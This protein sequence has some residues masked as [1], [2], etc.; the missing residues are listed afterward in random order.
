[1]S[2]SLTPRCT[3]DAPFL[4]L[5]LGHLAPASRRR[6]HNRIW[7]LDGTVP[8]IITSPSKIP[9]PPALYETGGVVPPG[10]FPFL[11]TSGLNQIRMWVVLKRWGMGNGLGGRGMFEVEAL[12]C[13]AGKAGIL[14]FSSWGLVQQNAD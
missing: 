3:S 1:M 12:L 11:A 7:E 5:V 14:R 4:N 9:V 13:H 8:S 10:F 2:D 6:S